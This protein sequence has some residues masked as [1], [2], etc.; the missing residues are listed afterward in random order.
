MPRAE[1]AARE[2]ESPPPYGTMEAEPPPDT[3]PAPLTGRLGIHG[4]RHLDPV[5]LAALATEAPVL[6][7]GLHGT[8]KSL[9]VERLAGALGLEFRHYNTSLLSYDDL[10]GIP[11]PEDGGNSLRFVHTPAAVWGAEFVFFD[12]ISRCRTD[13]QNKLFPII[14]EKKVLGT[15]LQRLK[16]RWAAMN[17][18]SADDDLAGE[19]SAYHGSVPLDPALVDRFPFVITV[20]SWEELSDAERRALITGS[21]ESAGEAE[22]PDFL[23]SAI[24][25]CRRRLAEIEAEVLPAVTDYLLLVASQ[26]GG[27]GL[28][29]SPRRA[30]MLARSVLGIHAARWTLASGHEDLNLDESAWL[31]LRWGLP[32]SAGEEPPSP[33][34]L[35][36]IHR[37]AWAL[38]GVDARN[39]RR[40]LLAETDP[41][42]R[43]VLAEDLGL[44][45]SQLALLV[46]QAL[47]ETNEEPRR[48]ALATA[49]FLGFRDRHDLTPAAWEPVG[50]LARTVLAPQELC[51]SRVVSPGDRAMRHD[52]S[53]H[54][55]SRH[56]AGPPHGPSFQK[57]LLR[58]YL[59]QGFPEQWRS[60]DWRKAATEFE[61]WLLRLS[62]IAPVG[63]PA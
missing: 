15:A 35:L 34:K 4:W 46:T 63:D 24:E 41:V 61:E 29:I 37:Q 56:S 39:P 12:E 42:R 32:Q 21:G 51:Y 30:R 19:G 14:H 22:D 40:R 38:A 43:L 27:G 9:L 3:Q 7:I 18:P 62:G 10:V 2:V 17:P 1:Q 11:V 55:Q 13:V 53:K 44:G 54:L 26:L 6:L 5:I 25:T 48:I 47:A 45:E 59:L 16:H 52:I 49:L 58:N 60:H 50:D 31:A 23:S 36:A 20:P 8:A 33:A 57:R 28:P